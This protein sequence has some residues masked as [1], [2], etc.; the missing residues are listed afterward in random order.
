MSDNQILAL[1]VGLFVAFVGGR[2]IVGIVL[3]EAHW[4]NSLLDADWLG[5]CDGDDGGGDGGGD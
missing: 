4:L 5:D 3:P 1:I 2:Y